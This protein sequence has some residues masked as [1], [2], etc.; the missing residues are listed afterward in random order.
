MVVHDIDSPFKDFQNRLIRG[1]CLIHNYV[2]LRT[3]VEG[4]D[5]EN[6]VL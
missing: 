3:G 5:F 4:I 2:W 6:F 1:T